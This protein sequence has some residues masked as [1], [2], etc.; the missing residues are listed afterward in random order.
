MSDVAEL[1]AESHRGAAD[2]PVV[3]VEDP[4]WPVANG[5]R[6]RL[7]CGLRRGDGTPAIRPVEKDRGGHAR[8]IEIHADVILRDAG[9]R[10]ARQRGFPKL[11]VTIVL[12]EREGRRA[13]SPIGARAVIES[14]ARLVG[15][16]VGVPDSAQPG[17]ERDIRPRTDLVGRHPHVGGGRKQVL[18]HRRTVPSGGQIGRSSG[19]KNQ[20]GK[21]PRDGPQTAVF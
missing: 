15:R 16:A 21:P 12:V 20:R 3:A 10:I 6:R 19:N 17:V 13:P 9:H 4:R 8:R 7:G 1:R 18:H 14:A 5:E 11:V 2:Y